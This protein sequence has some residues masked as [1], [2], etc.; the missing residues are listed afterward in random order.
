MIPYHGLPITPA[1]VAVRAIGGDHA[2][3]CSRTRYQLS[4]AL[5]LCQ[6]MAFD[7]GAYPAWREG[8]PITDWS[9]FYEWV[10]EFHRY[11]QFDFA[12]IPD[13]IDGDE[14]A[15]DDLINQ[16]PW[17]KSNPAVGAP[18]WHMHESLERLTRL[19]MNFGRICIG[20]SG[21]FATVGSPEWWIRMCSAMDAICDKS[22]RPICKI[23]G[24]RM[25]NPKIFSKLPLASAD[26]T[27]IAR[28]HGIDKAWKGPYAPPTREARADVMRSRIEIH[29]ALSLWDKSFK[30]EMFIGYHDNLR[31][32]RF[33]LVLDA[34]AMP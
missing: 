3:V 28:N 18:V 29:Q 30:D 13:V 24:L 1:T 4:L 34:Y 33:A 31:E 12:V 9:D 17:L 25:L 11:P 7:N 14:K 21:Q 26:S 10:A 19:A 23:H 22:G 32:D 27:N 16:W 6:S 15:N 5:E 8:K 20:S 2:F